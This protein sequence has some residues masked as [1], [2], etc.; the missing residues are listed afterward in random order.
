MNNIVIN[1]AEKVLEIRSFDE[2]DLAKISELVDDDWE[3]LFWY[4]LDKEKVID[5]VNFLNKKYKKLTFYLWNEKS[6]IPSSDEDNNKVLIKSLVENV[7]R[8]YLKLISK[9]DDFH[10][11]YLSY[12]VFGY[13][14]G[15]VTELFDRVHCS[16]DYVIEVNDM[17]KSKLA[18]IKN[19]HLS[20]FERIMACYII[21]EDWLSF[22]KNDVSDRNSH[23]IYGALYFQNIVC[24][25][26]S[27]AVLRA[28]EELG[29]GCQSVDVKGAIINEVCFDAHERNVINITDPKYGIDGNYFVDLTFDSDNF[30]DVKGKV[31]IDRVYMISN[32]ALSNNQLR[33]FISN[34]RGWTDDCLRSDI[35]SNNNI[36]DESII[37]CLYVVMCFLYGNEMS[38]DKIRESVVFSFCFRYLKI[39]GR[40][41]S[42]ISAIKIKVNNFLDK[43]VEKNMSANMK[44]F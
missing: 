22:R 19:S 8:E 30:K 14:G 3:I 15:T 18:V 35:V 16:I 36:S 33:N 43:F 1:S 2:F 7:N 10:N 42:E 12:P 28:Y 38:V 31:N 26:Y 37:E 34:D 40:Q 13:R 9:F 24:E 27:D 41:N 6:L 32:F 39:N 29:I 11:F 23:N 17:I 21:L 25:G 4:V 44:K 5:I 20:P